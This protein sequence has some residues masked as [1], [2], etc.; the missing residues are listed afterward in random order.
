MRR[1]VTFAAVLCMALGACSSGSSSAKPAASKIVWPAPADPLA[2]TR[3][4]GLVADSQENFVHHVHAHLDVFVNGEPVV[5]PAG[6]GINI[7]DPAVHVFDEGGVK[8]Y[9]GINPAC[10]QAC[11]SPL[12]THD[13]TGVIHTES[14]T[15]VDNTLGELFVE[16]GVK[17]D[18]KCVDKY[19][20][21]D[22]KIAVY[23]DGTPFTGDPRRIGLSD[24]KEIAVVIGSPP[25]EI[26][27]TGDFSAA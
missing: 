10:K 25:A 5:V 13:I 19:C 12:H 16:W 23:V 14:P 18:T 2:R 9:G 15:N 27:K 22:T 4:A 1:I 6:I 26:P 8:S 7:D 24:Q 17:L 11:I 20:A 21:P 3:A